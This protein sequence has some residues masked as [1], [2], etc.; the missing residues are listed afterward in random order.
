[1]FTTQKYIRNRGKIRNLDPSVD[2]GSKKPVPKSNHKVQYPHS[3]CTIMYISSRDT[4]IDLHPR[5]GAQC[6]NLKGYSAASM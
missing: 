3:L 4:S 5:K 6:G 1:M 2:A